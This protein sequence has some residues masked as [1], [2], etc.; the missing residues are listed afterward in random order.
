MQHA[1]RTPPFDLPW[2]HFVVALLSLPVAFGA[3]AWGG[4]AITTAMRGPIALASVHILTLGFIAMAVMGALA[5]MVPVVLGTAIASEGALRV[6][7]GLTALGTVAL[8]AGFG[9]RESLALIAG[10]GLAFAGLVLFVAVMGLTVSRVKKWEMTA[11]TIAMAL[12]FLALGGLLGLLSILNMRLGFSSLLYG[13]M[14]VHV[15]LLVGGWLTLL[16][17]GVSYKLLPM[18]TL[19]YGHP[20]KTARWVVGLLASGSALWLPVLV[21]PGLWP[22][23]GALLAVGASL[24]AWDAYRLVG[25]RKK[26]KLDTGLSLAVMGLGLLPVL[27]TVGLAAGL[28]VPG[29]AAAYGFLLLGGWVTWTLIGYLYKIIPFIVWYHRFGQA[30]GPGPR[31]LAGDLVDARMA[32][33]AQALLG[34][35]VPAGALGLGLQLAPVFTAGAA[36]AAVGAT[37]A[38]ADLLASPY[39]KGDPAWSRSSGKPSRTSSTPSSGSTSSISA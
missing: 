36:L 5:Q 18:F 11:A 20:P 38:A 12:G 39:R 10:G 9:A 13:A 30:Q 27:A 37:F 1:S 25:R 6:S 4:E 15:H 8:V 24:Y 32:K 7:H 16:T 14:P 2:R 28:G 3:A 19:A 17:A 29:A 33:A 22:L 31:P 34:L 23:P 21:W 26:K 35:G